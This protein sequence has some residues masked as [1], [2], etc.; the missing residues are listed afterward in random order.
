MRLIV[1][2]AVIVKA[3]D[4]A[5]HM[6]TTVVVATLAY[7]IYS[8]FNPPGTSNQAAFLPVIAI[9]S[10]V[11]IAILGFTRERSDRR[12]N[13]IR[14]QSQIFFERAALALESV[15]G[16]LKDQNNDRVTWL[17]AARTLRRVVKLRDQILD[18]D[19]LAAYDLEAD[20]AR[21]DLYVALSQ[22]DSDGNRTALDPRFFYGIPNWADYETLDEVAMASSRWVKGGQVTID[23][24]LPSNSTKPL[25]IPTKLTAR[26]DD[27]DRSPH[28][29]FTGGVF[30]SRS[31]TMGQ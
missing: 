4:F 23:R 9:S 15:V 18:P 7:A 1:A 17:R 29:F 24:N 19:Y 13:A 5:I 31:V 16:L 20:K 2:L 26:S 10:G 27:R 6:L 11:L 12:Q 8:A 3:Q 22:I 30:V 21:A 25:R 14:S 28:P